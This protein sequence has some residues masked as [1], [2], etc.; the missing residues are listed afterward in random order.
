MI[1]YKSHDWLKRQKAINNGGKISVL[2]RLYPN[3]LSKL[4][5]KLPPENFFLEVAYVSQP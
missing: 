2:S 1:N 5:I 3:K 4:H